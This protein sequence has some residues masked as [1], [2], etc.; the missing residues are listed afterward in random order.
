MDRD[1][2]MKRTKEVF[3]NEFEIEESQLLP[4]SG[5]YEELALDSLDTVDLVV[6]LEREFGVS[7]DRQADEDRLRGM[8]TLQDVYDFITSK[9]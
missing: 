5:L 7:I 2:I 6:A 4:T 9:L 3:V 8:R 1:E